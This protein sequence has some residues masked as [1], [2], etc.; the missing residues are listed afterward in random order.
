MVIANHLE[1]K[2]QML[3]PKPKVAFVVETLALADQQTQQLSKYI[4]NA[5]VECRTGNRGGDCRLQLHIK[6][7]LRN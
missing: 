5:H 4:H 7:T 6:D 3:L 1:E 2:S